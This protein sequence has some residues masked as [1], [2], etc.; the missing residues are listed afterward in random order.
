[1]KKIED[2]EVAQLLNNMAVVTLIDSSQ[3]VGTLSSAYLVNGNLTDVVLVFQDE[4]KQKFK[5]NDMISIKI[6]SSK[7]TV[8]SL[9]DESGAIVKKFY[10]SQY[11]F[12]HPLKS[13]K[14]VSPEMVQLLNP[15]FD[16]KIKIYSDPSGQSWSLDIN[17]ARRADDVV[18]SY[19]VTKNNKTI[20]IKR[21]SYKEDFKKLFGD[22][23][24]M[25]EV[26]MSEMINFD[27]FSG[28][29][30]LYDNYCKTE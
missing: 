28:H 22:C 13:S 29:V 4:S 8:F 23:D 10:N 30:L 15:A 14:K 2:A 26:V 20:I 11:V 24:K 18:N 21:S 3:L 9:Q 7:P 25:K 6:R 27:Y 5:A 17:G 16:K 1:M 12:E 19:S